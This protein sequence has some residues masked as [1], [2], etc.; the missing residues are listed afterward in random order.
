MNITSKIA[1][2]IAR[3]A[4]NE[5]IKQYTHVIQYTHVQCTD[6]RK[7]NTAIRNYDTIQTHI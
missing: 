2:I 1:A 5:T 6:I 3:I 4:S 7:Y